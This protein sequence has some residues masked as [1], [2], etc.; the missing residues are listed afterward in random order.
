MQ[1]QIQ[2]LIALY[3]SKKKTLR[4]HIVGLQKIVSTCREASESSHC[5]SRKG[6]SYTDSILL[7]WVKTLEEYTKLVDGYDI[8]DLH[9]LGHSDV[10]TCL[11]QFQA[12][13]KLTAAGQEADPLESG[14]H[15]T[16]Y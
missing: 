13:E 8:P 4:T 9:P 2:E 7:P 16:F 5:A 1:R 6:Q 12:E 11:F 14:T 3:S 15:L 10:K